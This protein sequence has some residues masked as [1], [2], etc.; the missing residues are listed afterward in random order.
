MLSV[1]T[2]RGVSTGSASTLVA[3]GALSIPRPEISMDKRLS[4]GAA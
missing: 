3:A 4:R 1:R 2:T